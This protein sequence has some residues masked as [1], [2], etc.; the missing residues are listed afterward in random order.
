MRPSVWRI[1]AGVLCAALDLGCLQETRRGA[2]FGPDGATGF[3]PDA[4]LPEVPSDTGSTEP[5]AALT[6]D[7]GA[8]TTE[9]D[10]RP[11]ADTEP[12][13]HPAPTSDAAP[14][15]DSAQVVLG[16]DARGDDSAPTADAADGGADAS[17]SAGLP[18]GPDAT[19][20]RTTSHAWFAEGPSCTFELFNCAGAVDSY[21][22]DCRFN[23]PPGTCTCVRGGTDTV[24]VPELD[25]AADKLCSGDLYGP[26]DAWIDLLETACG[27]TLRYE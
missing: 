1:A 15:D 17:D 7:A 12:G 23:S 13:T 21:E 8:A 4:T 3:L 2:V 9:A 20:C 14:H 5:D 24:A 10:T 27:V 22:V 25:A 11:G 26:I 6:A 18:D 16:A 19:I